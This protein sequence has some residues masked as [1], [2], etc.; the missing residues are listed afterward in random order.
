M[1]HVIQR[2]KLLS[3][4]WRLGLLVTLG[5]L[6]FASYIWAQSLMDLRQQTTQF[7]AVFFT[8]FFLYL[9]SSIFVLNSRFHSPGVALGV[10]F[11]FAVLF[12]LPM[13][14]M[15]PTLSDDMFRYVWDG[16]VQAQGIS[17]YRY[18]PD[19]SELSSLRQDDSSIWP[20]IN[21]K[22]AV[23][24]YPPGAQASF[25]G[26]WHLV[27]DSVGGFKTIFVLAE[28]LAVVPLLLLLRLFHQPPE[29]SLIYLWSPLL[30]F[31]VAHAGHVDG[32]LLPLLILAFWARVRNRPWLLGM[33][34]GFAT[35]FK[36]FPALLLPAL[37]PPPRKNRIDSLKTL[38]G[39]GVLIT[40]A[41]L[42][43]ILWSDNVIGFLPQ[44]LDE[45]FNLGL[46]RLVFDL[47]PHL[48]ISSSILANA[49]T[50][51][52]LGV[53][54]L[55]FLLKPVDSGKAALQRCLWLIAWFTLFSQNLF[56]WYLLWLLPLITLF[57]EPGKFMG[58]RIT[59]IAA[60]FIFSGTIAL[61][62]TFFIDWRIIP[63]AQWAE[64]LPLYL[65]II[66]AYSMK[67]FP[68]IRQ[69]FPKFVSMRPGNKPLLESN[70]SSFHRKKDE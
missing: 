69:N 45:N 22:S 19:S 38:L 28:L 21:R 31:E 14:T 50:F 29:R 42:P 51:G 53:A 25:L 67:I 40:F 5:G 43:Y 57:L 18:P 39:F 70:P 26:I 6:T 27:G 2:V 66:L 62:Y 1:A 16:R 34:L 33:S 60:W 41:Y 23:T 36:L 8:A 32:I 3:K 10:I 13:L 44:Y 64:Y 46:A 55:F 24:I 68:V 52:G 48:N 20:N 65:L 37:I 54:G 17:P 30:I 12:R 4:H 58:I 35:L 7:E 63:W 47:A 61:A 15:K 11:F 9:V 49:I 56:P 59:P